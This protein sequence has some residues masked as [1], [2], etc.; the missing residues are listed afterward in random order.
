MK[1]F[2]FRMRATSV[3]IFD[4]GMSTRR[5]FDPQALRIRVSIS[6]IGSV[7][8]MKLILGSA[9]ILSD[10]ADIE[11]VVLGTAKDLLVPRRDSRLPA[12]LP[13]ARDHPEQCQL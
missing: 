12:C 2:S 5:C 13:H 4:T 10:V 3:F 1:S 7:I 8:L 6:A 11:F 9:R